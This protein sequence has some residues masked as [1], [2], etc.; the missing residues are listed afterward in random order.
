MLVMNIICAVEKRIKTSVTII[1][2]KKWIKT[3][4]TVS[5][6]T[7]KLILINSKHTDNDTMLLVPF[8]RR[9]EG[10]L[11]DIHLHVR[12]EPIV[13]LIILFSKLLYFSTFH[14]ITIR[15]LSFH[16]CTT[17]TPTPLSTFAL[18]V[19]NRLT[20]IMSFKVSFP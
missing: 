20:V 19:A 1:D 14:K 8:Y 3:I 7:T 2:R 15:F 10:L 18:R 4:D 9:P 6:L 13:I 12:Q 17:L 16:I 11:Q 5:I